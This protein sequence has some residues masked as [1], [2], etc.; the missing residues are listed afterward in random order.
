MAVRQL[1]DGGVDGNNL[2][3]S[4]TDKV[5]FYG[6]TPVVQPTAAAQAAVTDSS[7]GTAA[8]A[9]GI[10]TITATY[11]STIIA[12]AIATIAAQTNAIRT[13]LVNTGIMKGS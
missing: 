3:Q 1:S 2:G 13:A 12:N 7:G 6:V 10:L 9:T 4:A 11:N 5:G 8:A